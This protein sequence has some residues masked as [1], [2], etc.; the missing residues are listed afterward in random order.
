[1]YLNSMEYVKDNE[2]LIHDLVQILIKNDSIK[3]VTHVLECLH[4][5]VNYWKEIGAVM[6]Y[7]AF[8]MYASDTNTKLFQDFVNFIDDNN[9]DTKNTTI[10]TICLMIKW[11]PD[12]DDVSNI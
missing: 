8:K 2:E 1:M 3:T 10:M 5:I 12:K 4:L 11:T 6:V 7:N 9:A